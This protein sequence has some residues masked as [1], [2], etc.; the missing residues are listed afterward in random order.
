MEN[1][2]KVLMKN[3]VDILEDRLALDIEVIEIGE[4]SI[5]A[6]YFVI[7]SG[8]TEL[9]TR[10]LYEHVDEEIKKNLG[11]DPLR[12]EGMQKGRWIAMDYGSV[13]VHIFHREDREYYGL[14]RLW[15]HAP[16]VDI[17]NS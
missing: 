9:Q 12:C 16:H 13:I 2:S 3:I 15:V 7:A 17:H 6:D 14:E 10:A 5:I 11:I 8:K 1:E 4:L